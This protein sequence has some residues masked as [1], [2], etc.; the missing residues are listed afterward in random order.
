[1]ECRK[2]IPLEEFTIEITDYEE[3]GR[4][5]VC[6]R[7]MTIKHSQADLPHVCD[8]CKEKDQG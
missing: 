4:C 1:M 8:S 2:D 7:F 6:G 3:R 5:S